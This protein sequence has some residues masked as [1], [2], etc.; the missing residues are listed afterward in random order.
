M[1]KLFINIITGAIAL[2][3]ITI[4]LF[5]MG[6]VFG[7]I[8]AATLPLAE[9]FGADTR[10]EY[11]IVNVATITITLVLLFLIGTLS[12]SQAFGKRESKLETF[13]MRF[14]PGYVLVRG[15]TAQIREDEATLPVVLVR[16]DDGANIGFEIEREPN[17]WV[18]VFIPGSPQPWSGGLIH[19]SADRVITL[20]IPYAKA[21]RMFK[22]MGIGS[23]AHLPD[24][25][26]EIKADGLVQGHSVQ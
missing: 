7:F 8:R 13:M 21:L 20:E 26:A 25:N 19:M 4:L 1:R 10:I 18:T 3:P 23:A 11:L 16:Q 9:A 17:G 14:I 24:V 5:I 22:Q 12:K 15:L 6:K 2:L